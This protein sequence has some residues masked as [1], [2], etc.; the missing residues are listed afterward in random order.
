MPSTSRPLWLL[1]FEGVI[2]IA[3]H[4]RPIKGSW[5]DWRATGSGTSGPPTIWSP[6]VVTLLH[7]ALSA[8]V[9]VVWLSD[10]P[11]DSELMLEVGL[12]TLARVPH[13][14]RGQH[15]WPKLTAARAVAVNRP[16]LWTDADLAREHEALHWARTRLSPTLTLTPHILLGLTPKMVG[17]IRTWIAANAQSEDEGPA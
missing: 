5:D 11:L 3:P 7:E 1:D 4:P 15:V 13:P 12:P 9:E 8:G 6:S 17:Q 16:L 2:G 10:A 14:V